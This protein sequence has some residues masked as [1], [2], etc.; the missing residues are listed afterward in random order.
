MRRFNVKLEPGSLQEDGTISGWGSIYGNK[1]AYGDVVFEGAYDKSLINNPISSVKMLWQHKTDLPIGKWEVAETIGKGLFLKGRILINK[2]IEK[3]D[4][5]YTLVKE[6]I[7]DGLSIGY[8]IDKHE[9]DSKTETLNLL[10]LSLK[11]TSLV[12]FPANE[13]SRITEIK[14]IQSLAIH[15][16]NIEGILR[17][18]GCSTKEAL[19]IISHGVKAD[20]VGQSDSDDSEELEEMNSMLKDAVSVLTK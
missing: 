16:R 13:L 1:D 18:G 8:Q 20:L 9:Y 2:G 15:K 3:A 14:S 17:D 10:E 19:A 7:V 11:E 4:E 12:T 6:G 5:A